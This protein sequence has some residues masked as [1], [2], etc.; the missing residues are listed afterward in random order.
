MWL[1]A[2]EFSIHGVFFVCWI[3]AQK[4]SLLIAFVLLFVV[5]FFIATPAA[6]TTNAPMPVPELF[7][8]LVFFVAA[9]F[10]VNVQFEGVGQIRRFPLRG[11]IRRR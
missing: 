10:S 8:L 11:F 6:T 5:V 9:L 3:V 4:I 1:P 7:L 2:S